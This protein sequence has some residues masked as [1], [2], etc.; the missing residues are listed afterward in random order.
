MNKKMLEKYAR[1]V[2]KSGV[3]LQP[4]QTLVLN[5]P[6]ECA[7]FARMIA[8]AAYEEGAR[9]VV[10]V[11][12]DELSTK[13]R[14]QY[15]PEEVFSEFPTWTKDMYTDCAR[16]NA[17]FISISA[18]DPE[19]LKE[20]PP[21]RVSAA[22]K[23]RTT[24]LQEFNDRTMNN[25]NTW[26]VISVP[27]VGWASKVF[28]EAAEGQAITLLWDSILSAVR[29]DQDDP[30]AAWEAHK[31]NLK[32]SLDFLNGCDFRYLKYS[33]GLETNLTIELPKNHLWL[34]GSDYT[35]EGLEFIANM[36][37]EEVYTLPKRDGVNG[38]VH[39]SM[40]LNYNGNLIE[41][42]SLTFINGRIT[43]FTA[44]RGYEILKGL[45]DTDEGA[46]Y[47]GEVALVPHDSPIS[48]TGILFYN[49]LFDENAS[50]HLAI[51]KAY[52]VCIKDG[53]NMTREQLNA[54]GANDSVTHVDFMIGTADL[55]ITGVCYD[56]TVVPVFVDGNF[57]F[58]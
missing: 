41:D 48:N 3:N 22:Q 1:M 10:M 50:C 35:P 42:F 9:D 57:A 17:T 7:Y 13:I 51:G 38:I 25:R 16:N 19:L 15:A 56:G 58:G 26:C 39:S 14:F 11:W 12:G 8:E 54:I 29:A 46:S 20:V 43:E 53:E 49:T 55:C 2:V 37:T 45:I 30:V 31:I 34:G 27:S 18:S 23:A 24:A 52:P 28:P 44:K 33:N 21:N 4:S 40:P 5:S 47:L 6:I 32:K 36:P